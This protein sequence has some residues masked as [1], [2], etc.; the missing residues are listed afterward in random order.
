VAAGLAPELDPLRAACEVAIDRLYAAG[1]D[2]LMIV[3]ATDNPSLS[4]TG[5]FGRYGVPVPVDGGWDTEGDDRPMPLPLLVGAWLLR[6]RPRTPTRMPVNVPEDSRVSLGALGRSLAAGS[7]RVAMLVLGDGSACRTPQAPGHFDERAEAYD[8]TVA[9]ALAKA[10]AETL[11][12]LDVPLSRELQ[13][14]GR[15]AW[16]VLAGAAREGEFEAE[17]LYDEAPYGV[18]Y[19]VASW[20]R[21]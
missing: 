9:A 17:L 16:Q 11:A 13:V 20:V 5:D 15:A 14:A 10:D 7:Q 2:T 8:Q 3:G 12:G 19:L 1:A 21:R 18:G 6:D 4:A